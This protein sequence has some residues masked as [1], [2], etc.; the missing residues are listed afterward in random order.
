M[1]SHSNQRSEMWASKLVLTYPIA[2]GKLEGGYEYTNTD[3]AD[4]YTTSQQ[5]MPSTDDH[6]KEQMAAGFLSY[7]WT[8]GK[9]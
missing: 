4:D 3:R 2:T 5:F 1:N 6:I 8:V 9:V 7:E